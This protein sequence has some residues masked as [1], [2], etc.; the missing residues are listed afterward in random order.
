MTFIIVNYSNTSKVIL[1]AH[2]FYILDAFFHEAFKQH[3][4][5]YSCCWDHILSF[6]LPQ[7]WTPLITTVLQTQCGDFARLLFL[8]WW[9]FTLVKKSIN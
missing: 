1:Y 4:I 3:F 8:S 2:I 6:K 7:N 9:C 5:S